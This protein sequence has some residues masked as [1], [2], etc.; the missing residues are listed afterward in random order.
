MTTAAAGRK[1]WLI[2]LILVVLVGLAIKEPELLLPIGPDQGT[3]AYVAERILDG[4]LPYVDAWDNKPPGTYYLHAAVLGLVPRGDRWAGTCIQGTTQPCG[5]VALQVA[6]VIWTLLTA[7]A[8]LALARAFG[9]SPLGALASALLFVVFA[10]VSQLSKEGSTPEKE[11]LLPM[12]LSYLCVVKARGRPGL[13]VLG[14]ALAGG[15]FLFKQT[16]ISIPIALGAFWLSERPR[17]FG[18]R[19]W[20]PFALGYVVPLLLVGGY[21]AAR[22]GLDELWDAAFGYNLVQARTSAFTI[23]RAALAGA[24]HVFSGSSALLWLLG[25]G[26]ALIVLKRRGSSSSAQMLLLWWAVAD[27]L[28]LALGGAKFAQVYFVQVVPSLALLGG[29][30]I[31]AAWQATRGMNLVR[32]YAALFIV[33][34]FALSSEFQATVTLRAWNERTPGHSSTPSEHL[35]ADRF[36]AGSRWWRRRADFCLGRQFRDL[37][38]RPGERTQP[39]LSGLSAEPRVRRPRLPG[40][41]PGASAHVAGRSTGDHRHRSGR[42]AQRS[43][44]SPRPEPVELSRASG[45]DQ[46]GLCVDERRPG[47]MAGVPTQRYPAQLKLA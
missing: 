8:V 45:V 3:Y 1:T 43:G 2:G 44:R 26:G 38:V 10:N 29:L 37:P 24:W 22:G 36:L 9:F 35:L 13:L 40:T 32:A 4:Q 7:L 33:A 31:D 14:G 47:R 34:V 19:A 11:L 12:V 46:D 28:S 15:A 42:R 25:L 18:P 27:A 5:Y 20:L 39:L 6:D 17:W 30:A 21:F 41:P 23:P 16:A